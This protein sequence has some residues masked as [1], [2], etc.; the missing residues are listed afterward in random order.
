MY[1][2]PCTRCQWAASLCMNT[3]YLSLPCV[4]VSELVLTISY[5][6]CGIDFISASPSRCTSQYSL[7]RNG[8][9]NQLWIRI[10][11]R[12]LRNQWQIA[13]VWE[14]RWLHEFSGHLL[15]GPHLHPDEWGSKCLWSL[16]SIPR[17]SL[18]VIVPE[19]MD[20]FLER[21]GGQR[22]DDWVQ[23]AVDGQNK[24]HH[25]RGDSVWKRKS[26]KIP[27]CS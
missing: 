17:P 21:S 6:F 22:V 27:E 13:G 19:L 7:R 11:S 12:W 8:S 26:G 18:S 9:P 2:Y 5:T 15:H 1:E 16:L 24:N 14:N 4:T 3:S 23:G 10:E 25:P 20:H